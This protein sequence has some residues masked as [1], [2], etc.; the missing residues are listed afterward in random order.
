MLLLGFQSGSTARRD[1][2]EQARN[3]GK[4][5]YENP[6]TQ[7][8]SVAEF[9]KALDMA[10]DSARER[11][12]YGIALLHA[13][14]T[15]DGIAE[16]EKAQKQDPKIPHTWFNLGI[17][18]KKDSKYDQAIAEFEGMVKLV[19]NE[20]ISHYNLG[21]LYKLNGK[22]DQAL[23]E[24]ELSAKLNPRLAGPHFQLYN[25]Y[26]T[27][28]RAE[29]ATR[30]QQTFQDIKKQQA[31]A[32]VPEDLEW[33]Y[34][35]E[36]YDI[37]DPVNAT[38]T[39]PA[40]PIR[41]NA[42]KLADGIDPAS[43]G[44]VTA[45]IDG[46]GNPEIIAWSNSGI[47]V[48]K[49]G[50]ASPIDCGLGAVRDVIS[51]SPGDFNNDGL[52][53]LAILTKSG[54]E[55]WANRKGK[56]EKLN[57]VIPEGAYNKAVWV[58]Y[59]HDYDLDLFLLGDKSALLRNNGAAGFSNVSNNFPFV[60]GR[61]VDGAMFDITPDTDGMDLAVI[62]SDRPG[63]LY[64]DKL[65]GRYEAQD[66]NAIPVGAKS[67]ASVDLDNDGA[68]DLIVGT[69]T[70]AFP[71]FNRRGSFEKGTAL[72][73]SSP[74]LAVVDFENRGLEDIAISGYVFRNEGLGKFSE[75]KAP[76]ADAAALAVVDFDADGRNDLVEVQRDGFLTLLHNDT[77]TTNGWLSATLLGVK[78]LKLAY[79]SK[80]EVKAGAHYQKRSYFGQPLNFGLRGYKEA[81]TVRIT[82][83]NGLIQNEVHQA[84]GK[85]ATYKEAQRLSGSCPMIFTWNGQSFNFLTDVLGVAPLGASSG[86]GNYFPVDHD[87][88]VQVPGEAM[89]PRN[90]KY[91]VRITEELH[92]VSYLD[93]I[94]LIAVDHPA[95]TS[96]YTNDKFKSPP[97]PDF[98]LFGVTKPIHP[99]YAR[100]ENANNVL[101]Q[102]LKKDKRYPD[103]FPRSYTGVAS[104]HHLDL[105]FG[106]A[107]AAN[108]GV[109][110]LN[111]WVDWADGSTFLAASQE[112]KQGLV[113]PYLQVKNARGQ[114]QTVI[115]DMGIPAG[116][117][118]T[119]SVD[120]TGKFLSASREVRIVT[121]LCVYW[122]EIFLSEDTAA[123]DTVLT[124][125]DAASAD[126][127]FPRLLKTGDSSRT[128]A[129][130]EFSL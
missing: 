42:Q 56:F 121:N 94:Q 47:K 21:V 107:A 36:V 22:A 19:P 102:L 52:A 88:Y 81:E 46:D 63:V 113:M 73:S 49:R 59:D 71:L 54:A 95:I 122:D 28:N 99:K 111:G 89:V 130:R 60:Q 91:E 64:V 30:E 4:A 15:A 20:P 106:N 33:S 62:Y 119:I 67:I 101:P 68:T 98:R 11:I 61:A 26:R 77:E 38:E 13:A 31:G 128:Q 37:T 8:Q 50:S 53:D 16:L 29:D 104:L 92:E 96:I 12:N 41:L 123:P 65:G 110:I 108:R 114:W 18:Y 51:I 5:F 10:P 48:M 87:E 124:P 69:P 66:L 74:V 1:Q 85:S 79:G 75:T 93:R 34:Y 17:A 7:T 120:L 86:D 90:G 45:D 6:T 14:Q 83:P 112:S 55:L 116:K 35:S 27:L 70:G 57:V 25:A 58:D 23:K 44:L 80:I 100:D 115:Q 3:L 43:A 109:L 72:T 127:Q 118:K 9:K 129:A 78:N 103:S 105:D 126:L 40:K 76:V 2:L 82:W 97:F 32:A 117:P 84:A 39:E 24:F 125:V